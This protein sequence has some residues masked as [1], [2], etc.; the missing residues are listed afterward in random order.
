MTI[1]DLMT[2]ADKADHC[3]TGTPIREALQIIL[4]NP[5]K[6]AIVVVRDDDTV[7]D[8]VGIVTKTDLLKGYESLQDLDEPVEAIMGTSIETIPDTATKDQAAEHF[9]KTH[10]YNAFVVDHTD[11]RWVGLL[12]VL[13]V[14]MDRAKDARAW[15]WNREAG[16]L[17][18]L[19]RRVHSPHMSTKKVVN[20]KQAQGQ[21]YEDQH[22]FLQIAGATE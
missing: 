17:D 6:G 18:Y 19:T 22:T 5:G 16:S 21:D 8:P 9:E 15:P 7:H 14:A 11:G 20:N 4:A 1:V 3:Y 12:T 13:D 2:A 10:H